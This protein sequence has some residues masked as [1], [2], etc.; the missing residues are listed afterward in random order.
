MISAAAAVGF[1]LVCSVSVGAAEVVPADA[2][3]SGQAGAGA[4][5][6]PAGRK[7]AGKPAKKPP[8]NPAPTAANVKYGEHERQVL[9]FW[10]AEG[11]GPR[12]LLFFIHGGGWR[13][14]DKSGIRV[15]P[16]LQA[17]ISVVSINYRYTQLAGDVVP[18][19]KAPLHD[20]AR[21]LQFVRSKAGEW[22]LD[23][24]KVVASGGSAG[25]C[26]SL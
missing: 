15:A 10:K 2:K 20:A 21:A 26:S 18:P 3:A 17:G 13:N 4:G 12:P 19:V 1:S 25:A 14:G 23:K 24:T 6:K 5:Q 22:N 7:V 9:D 8:V 11:D 16:Y